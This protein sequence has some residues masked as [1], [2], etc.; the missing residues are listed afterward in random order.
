LRSNTSPETAI[1]PT[2]R[3]KKAAINHGLGEMNVSSS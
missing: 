3:K 2:K 1:Q